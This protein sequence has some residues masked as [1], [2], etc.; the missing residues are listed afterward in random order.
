MPKQGDVATRDYAIYAVIFFIH[1]SRQLCLVQN[2][3][4][5]PESPTN[6]E[7]NQG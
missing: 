6:A 4:N 3:K 5:S 1:G 2:G 7:T